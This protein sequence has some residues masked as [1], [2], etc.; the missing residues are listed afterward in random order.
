MLGKGLGLGQVRVRVKDK[1]RGKTRAI[2]H[3]NA[4]LGICKTGT[5]LG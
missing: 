1:G 3:E 2:G 4:L 5:W